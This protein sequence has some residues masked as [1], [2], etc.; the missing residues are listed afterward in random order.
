MPTRNINTN[1]KVTGSIELD[2][3]LYD[4]NDSA[5]TN[6]QVLSSTSTGTDWV[7]LSEIQGVDGT[8]TANYLSKWL[9]ADTIGN[10]TIYDNGNIGVGTTNPVETLSIPSGKGAML[11]FKRF[12]SNTGVV[13]AGIGSA[14]SLTATL[15]DEQGAILTSQFQYK[16]YLTTT[17]T[18]TYNSS[19]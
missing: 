4:G 10:S 8:G 16:F 11:G 18:G 13:P 15:N 2:G 9:D 12:Y 19:V 3:I 7:S 1:L 14:Y 6:G 5:G 17:G